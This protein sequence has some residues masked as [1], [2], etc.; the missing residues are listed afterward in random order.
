MKKFFI[1]TVVLAGFV[2][3]GC[4]KWLTEEQPGVTKLNEY[5]T[6]YATAKQNVIGC[7]VPLQWE[8]SETFF[9][10]WFIGDVMSDDALK[11]GGGLN[12][13]A[14]AYDMEFWLTQID[15]SL[16]RSFWKANYLGISRCNL[17]LTYIKEMPLDSTMTETAKNALLGEVRFLRAYQYFRLVRTYGAVPYID[18]VIEGDNEW[19]IPRTP[20][21]EVYAHILEDLAIAEA[22]LPVKYPATDLGR[23][24]K[25]AAQAMLEKVNLYLAG[26]GNAANRADGK[27]ASY[28]YGEA[29]K[30]GQTIYDDGNYSLCS[31]YADNFTLEG[32]NGPESVFEIQYVGNEGDG[33]GDWG[34]NVDERYGS[35]RGSMTQVETRS[36]SS[37][38]NTMGD[39][40][41]FNRPSENLFKEYEAGDIR[42]EVTIYRPKY[43]VVKDSEGNP[44]KTVNGTDSIYREVETPAQEIY[45]EDSLLSRKYAIYNTVYTPEDAEKCVTIY[46][47][48]HQTRGP[49][50]NKQIRYADVLLM[51]AEAYLGA[52]RAPEGKQYLNKV[53]ARVGLAD[54]DL[55]W[56]SLRHE[57][58]CELAMEGHRWFD[59]CR[60]GIAAEV[61]KAYEATESQ[62]YKDQLALGGG[63]QKG[64]HELLPIPLKEIELNGA[65]TQNPGY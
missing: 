3:S 12:D 39:G 60:W 16:V 32:E 38:I 13:M 15:N 17:A 42:R 4:T 2:L 47:L 30:W 20:A 51:L 46:K 44:Y 37:K 14:D 56:E 35:T 41:G 6:S 7:Y 59:L 28:Y 58:R 18:H 50:N 5:F 9:S 23:V 63:F 57:R 8:F 36:R 26:D 49:L 55:T 25:G 24:T 61:M 43:Y 31:A 40:Y 53:R 10:E 27:D 62:Q 21:K 65:M 54:V 52:G 29:I 48:E 1:Y 11:G 19:S 22:A 34:G 33:T 45:L 64:K